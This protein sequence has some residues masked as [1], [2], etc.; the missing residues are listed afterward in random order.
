MEFYTYFGR[1]TYVTVTPSHQHQAYSCKK[2]K[3]FKSKLC[4]QELY[5]LPND[6]KI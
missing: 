5:E 6:I 1:G 2:K 3:K 4:K